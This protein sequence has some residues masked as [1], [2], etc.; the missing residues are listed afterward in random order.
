M[1]V[2]NGHPIAF[3]QSLHPYGNIMQVSLYPWAKPGAINRIEL[4]PRSP[5]EIAKQ[6]LIVKTVRIG[7]LPCHPAR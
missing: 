5:E 3:N 1:V 6:K 7:T 2:I 4:W